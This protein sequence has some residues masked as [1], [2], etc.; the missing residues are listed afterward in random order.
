M[1]KM[2]VQ[3]MP[4][5][6]IKPYE[7]NP[8]KNA[9][10][11]DYVANS[12]KEFGFKQ[13]IVVDADHVIVVGHT[14]W[15]AAKKL[16]MKTVPVLVADDLT[17]EQAKAYRL[18]DNKTNEFSEWD[19]DL[20]DLE[21]DDLSDIDMSLFGFELDEDDAEPGEITEDEIP[22]EAEERCKPG[23]LWQLGN[24]RL[25]CGDSTDPETVGALMNG[26][27]A[28][29]VFTD[30]P[31]GVSYTDKNE[32][33]NSIDKPICVVNAIQND[34]KT[35]EEMYEFWVKAFK[36]LVDY[37][38][39]KMSYYITAPQG[40]DLLL[41]LTAVRDSGF[42]LRH[43]LVWNKNNHVL[44]RC[45]YNYKHEPI[46]YGWKQ[47]GT[48]TFY[49]NGEMKTSVWDIPR[50][51][52]SDLH[53]T[54]KP[55]E[56]I[57]NA[58]MNSTIEGNMVLDLFGGSGSTLIACE[59]LKRKCFMAELDPHYCDVIIERWENLTGEKAT[60]LSQG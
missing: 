60:L 35:P 29:M 9:A 1:P 18:A 34:S 22:E 17:P 49:G 10:A 16:K 23:D 58:L 11:V 19:D 4:I 47:K 56:L 7:R 39:D 13:P 6:D 12:I 45:D 59:Q 48:H 32:F 27:L 3:E 26:E 2:N 41:L 25:I 42:S 50:P 24:H 54:M 44:G 30:P 33:L 53:P 5:G 31:Y 52:R 21:M 28:D 8:R 20:L 43:V 55:I 51:Q 14:R 57:A 36:N 40:G 37:T 46:V 15:L 38:S